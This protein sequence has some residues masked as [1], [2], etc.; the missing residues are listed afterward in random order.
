MLLSG[1]RNKYILTF[2]PCKAVI[3]SRHTRFLV[4]NVMPSEVAWATLR[5]IIT[6][7]G[8]PGLFSKIE[9]DID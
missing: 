7:C 5:S 9:Q 6:V 3:L 4:I 8:L 2:N 1:Q